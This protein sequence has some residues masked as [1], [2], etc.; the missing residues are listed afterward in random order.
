M[1]VPSGGSPTYDNVLSIGGGITS[2]GGG[3]FSISSAGAYEVLYTVV[4]DSGPVNF[5]A[6]IT[7]PVVGTLLAGSVYSNSRNFE[8]INGN[9][10]FQL[11]GPAQIKI[12]NLSSIGVNLVASNIG[13]AANSVSASI[14][15]KKLN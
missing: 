13:T 4:P 12:A 10:I 6:V 5:G 8:A 2:L 7:E 9:F 15:I 1:P 3:S 11:T 14:S